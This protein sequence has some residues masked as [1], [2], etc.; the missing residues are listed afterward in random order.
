MPEKTLHDDLFAAVPT[1]WSVVPLKDVVD[2][3]EGP[4]ILAKDFHDSG[5][6][7]LRLRSIQG[8]FATLDGADCLDPDMVEKRWSHFSLEVGDLL[9]STSATIGIVSEVSPAAQG[10]IPY[11]GIIRMRPRGQTLDRAFLRHFL[12]S[13]LFAAQAERMASGS[14][15]R[16]YGPTHLRQMSL[17]LPPLREQGVIA[18]ILDALD[19]KIELNRKMSATLEAMARTLFKSWFVDFDSVRAKAEGRNTGLSPEIAGLFPDS[20]AEASSTACPSGWSLRGLDEVASFLNGLALQKFPPKDETSTLPVIKIAQ[21]RAGHSI[22]A[23]RAAADL[24]PDY[25]VANG[26]I[27]FSWSGSLESHI[28]TGGPGA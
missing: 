16:H 25:V 14:V 2:F 6:P 22:G 18:H 9:V 21:L 7:L 8:R 15:M 12:K 13:S 19:D 10:A 23:D 4:G 26:D 1:H 17:V 3:Q 11:T 20:F 28:W 5:V 24:K 27:L